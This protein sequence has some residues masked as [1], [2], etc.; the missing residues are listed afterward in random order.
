MLYRLVVLMVGRGGLGVGSGGCPSLCP[1]RC[2]PESSEVGGVEV[3]AAYEFSV[4]EDFFDRTVPLV[5]PLTGGNLGD[6]TSPL[7]GAWPLTLAIAGAFSAL[8]FDLD[9]LRRAERKEGMAR[10]SVHH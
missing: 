3:P 2:G 4:E 5:L 8:M 7:R 1:L 10:G 9:L 6:S